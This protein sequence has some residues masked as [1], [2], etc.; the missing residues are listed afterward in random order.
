MHE[1]QMSASQPLVFL[2]H[3]LFPKLESSPLRG[4]LD[5]LRKSAFLLKHA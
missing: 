3:V 2:L 4:F 5:L 1:K